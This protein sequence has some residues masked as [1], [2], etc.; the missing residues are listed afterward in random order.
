MF[1]RKSIHLKSDSQFDVNY[2]VLNLLLNKRFCDS[3]NF[4]WDLYEFIA[5]KLNLQIVIRMSFF[6]QI[7]PKQ[8][9]DTYIYS[10]I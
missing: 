5:L 9:L 4:L 2:L 6:N 7:K 1:C 3:E 8:Q 10:E